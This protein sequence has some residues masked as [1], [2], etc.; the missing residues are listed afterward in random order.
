MN[1]QN[2]IKKSNVFNSNGEEQ[3]SSYSKYKTSLQ[4]IDEKNIDK[5]TLEDLRYLVKCQM[6]KIK[7]RSIK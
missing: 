1:T 4:Q 7:V 6:K 5:M 3:E 2:E